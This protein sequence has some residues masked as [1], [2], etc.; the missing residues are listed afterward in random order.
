MI[1]TMVIIYS[2]CATLAIDFLRKLHKEIHFMLEMRNLRKII[3]TI[4]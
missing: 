1:N 2:L 4:R 3:S